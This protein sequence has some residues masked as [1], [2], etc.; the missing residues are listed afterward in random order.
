M[1]SDAELNVKINELAPKIRR[2][3]ILGK[4]FL[5]VGLV[6]FMPLIILLSILV[7]FPPL[8]FLPIVASI[9]FYARALKYEGQLKEFVSDN[10][11]KGVLSDTF[12]LSVYEPL[13]R[14]EEP[15]IK[16]VKLIENWNRAGGSD[17][18][19]GYYRGVKFTFSDLHLEFV[20]GGKNKGRKTRF[21]GQWLILELAKE[22]PHAVQLIEDGKAK[23]DIETENIEFNRKFQIKTTDPHT[24]FYLLT[25]HFMEH[26]LSA[27]R[28]ANARTY[29]SF[30]GDCKQAHIA[31]H[32]GRDLFEAVDAKRLSVQNVEMMRNQM[33][34][35]AKYITGIIDELLLNQCLFG[36]T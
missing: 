7:I 15:V 4:I 24:A 28:R 12:Q 33:Q 16:D 22:L 18:I 32:S 36:A 1:M 20:S 13:E 31:L 11:I 2:Y 27:D 5:V 9:V 21:K 6:G 25:P 3:N 29:M 23:S 10:I 35:D 30:G 17:L 14:I 8:G 19:E 26:I 34:W